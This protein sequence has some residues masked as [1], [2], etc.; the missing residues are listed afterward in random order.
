MLSHVISVK[1]NQDIET[2]RLAKADFRGYRRVLVQD[3]TV[4]ERQMRL[5]LKTRLIVIA[6]ASRL[7]RGLEEVIWRK[8][9]GRLSLLKFMNYLTN[10]PANLLSVLNWQAGDSVAAIAIETALAKY[11]CYDKRKKRRNFSEIWEALA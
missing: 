7:Y 6:A 2:G 9:R 8:H 4:T 5:L 1:I 3:S 11:G 10:S